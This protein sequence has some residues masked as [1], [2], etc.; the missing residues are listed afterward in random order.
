MVLVYELELARSLTEQGAALRRM[1]HRSDAVQTLRRA[2]DL[3]SRCGALVLAQ[4]A[5]EELVVA[6]ARPRR[7]RVRGVDSLTASE[8]RV[9]RM[10]TTGMTNRDIAEALFVT[11]RT[12]TT[13]L[14]HVYQKLDV[15]G[16]GQLAEA[17][18]ADLTS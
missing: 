11:I 3:A 15:S 5:R 4:R 9:A 2:L 10:A 13:H 1:G 7:E 18:A 12:V 16:R 14:G 6:G 8:L 17:I